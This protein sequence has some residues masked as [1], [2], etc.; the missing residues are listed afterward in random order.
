MY[1]TWVKS[2]EN[3]P[4]PPSPRAVRLPSDDV[5]ASAADRLNRIAEGEMVDM[6][7]EKKSH[8]A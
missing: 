8:P 6:Q 2:V 1:Y 4:P 3:A 7:A 5:E